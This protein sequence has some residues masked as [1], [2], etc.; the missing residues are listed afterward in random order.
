MNGLRIATRLPPIYLSGQKLTGH[1][2][3]TDADA[4]KDAGATVAP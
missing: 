2:L 1:L 3:S 4:Q